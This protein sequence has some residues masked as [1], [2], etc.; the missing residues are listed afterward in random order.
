MSWSCGWLK[1]LIFILADMCK[2][3]FVVDYV[4]GLENDFPK[5]DVQVQSA[6]KI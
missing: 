1:D 3:A 2:Q 6:S 5:S 4:G